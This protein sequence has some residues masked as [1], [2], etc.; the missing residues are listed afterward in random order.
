MKR[1]LVEAAVAVISAGAII[2]DAA[3][4]RYCYLNEKKKLECIEIGGSGSGAGGGGCGGNSL[5]GGSNRELQWVPDYLG[6]RPD[7]FSNS[8]ELIDALQGTQQRHLNEL[9]SKSLQERRR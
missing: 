9:K 2:G 6:D 5:C 1:L 4:E 3:A 7:R 8:R